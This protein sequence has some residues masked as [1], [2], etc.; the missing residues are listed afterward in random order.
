[1]FF[2]HA[3]PKLIKTQCFFIL[4]VPGEPLPGYRPCPGINLSVHVLR[5]SGSGGGPIGRTTFE[6]IAP[7]AGKTTGFEKTHV[8]PRQTP[9]FWSSRPS[10]ST[11]QAQQAKKKLQNTS[12]SLLF[13]WPP[14]LWK[15]RRSPMDSHRHSSN[16]KKQVFSM[17]FAYATQ[18][19]KK[20]Q[21][22]F[23]LLEPVGIPIPSLINVTELCVTDFFLRGG[24][25]LAEGRA[26]QN[27]FWR[28]LQNCLKFR[29]APEAPTNP[30]AA[31]PRTYRQTRQN[32]SEPIWQRP[33]YIYA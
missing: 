13:F 19:N 2:E 5:G 16:R 15:L 21:C 7:R 32:P 29:V 4:L 12:I 6:N 23:I 30:I 27:A 25:C 28:S 3:T 1:M 9:Y 24:S 22:F 11:A 8:S 26:R 17:F 18:K 31:C 20:T 33:I 14:K 10:L